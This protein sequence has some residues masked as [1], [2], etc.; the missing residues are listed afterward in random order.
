[1]NEV[2]NINGIECYEQNGTAYLKLET[3]A[4]GLGFTDSKDGTEYV[5][6]AR[7]DKYLTELN[8]ATSG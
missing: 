2:M 6:W 4:K 7:V 8:F 5:R 3:V 1:M